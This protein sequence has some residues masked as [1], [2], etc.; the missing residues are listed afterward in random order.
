MLGKMV[1]AD[2]ARDIAQGSHALDEDINAEAKSGDM[3]WLIVC[4]CGSANP[5]RRICEWVRSERGYIMRFMVLVSLMAVILLAALGAHG[6]GIREQRPNFIGAELGGKGIIYSVDYERYFSGIVGIGVGFMAAGS[7][8]GG[9]GLFPLYLSVI[10]VGDMHSLY[11]SGG[12]TFAVG[13]ADWGDFE[14]EALGTFSIGYQ[15]QSEG[16]LFVR[17]TMSALFQGDDFL[18]WP[19]IAIGGSF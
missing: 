13:T 9:A 11:L 4:L 8:E 18:I 14:S 10:P 12:V 3:R 6:E 16:G 15:Y 17:P 19:G 2:R 1:F 5:Q 7:S